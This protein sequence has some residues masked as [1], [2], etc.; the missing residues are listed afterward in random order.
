M[1][2]RRVFAHVSLIGATYVENSVLGLSC[3]RGIQFC[4]NLL[5]SKLR[6]MFAWPFPAQSM[7]RCVCTVMN[8]RATD[9]VASGRDLMQGA[10]HMGKLIAQQIKPLPPQLELNMEK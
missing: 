9:A 6:G 1:S 7:R 8:P 4:S 2:S 5:V 3:V 10:L